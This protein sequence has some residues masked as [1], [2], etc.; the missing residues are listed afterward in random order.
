MLGSNVVAVKGMHNH[1]PRALCLPPRRPNAR[2]GIDA[3]SAALASTTPVTTLDAL[4]LQ[5][6]EIE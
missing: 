5:S 2:K 1:P 6:P 3:N 4:A